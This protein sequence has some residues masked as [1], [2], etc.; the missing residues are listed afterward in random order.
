MLFFLHNL[1][2]QKFLMRFKIF[3]KNWTFFQICK[4]DRGV[5]K[6]SSSSSSSSSSWYLFFSSIF[7][8]FNTIP[9]T[10]LV[11]RPRFARNKSFGEKKKQ[12]N[13]VRENLI[14]RFKQEKYK[15]SLPSSE[16]SVKINCLFFFF[17]EQNVSRTRKKSH[18]AKEFNLMP[19]PKISAKKKKRTYRWQQPTNAQQAQQEL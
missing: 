7:F 15:S 5:Q 8:F 9:E 10:P 1:I 13:W 4:G 2:V 18:Q 3:F 6:T 11:L 12:P 14:L 16:V 17:V 19:K